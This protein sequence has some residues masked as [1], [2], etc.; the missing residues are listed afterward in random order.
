MRE[1]C[2]EC[3]C[4]V[5]THYSQQA[6]DRTSAIPDHRSS[7]ENELTNQKV[8]F[9]LVYAIWCAFSIYAVNASILQLPSI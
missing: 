9:T 7:N 8:A 2:A 1:Y 3:E 5:S 6:R 4:P